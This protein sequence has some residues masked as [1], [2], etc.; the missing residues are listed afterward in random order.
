MSFVK[1][2]MM[3][4]ATWQE[5]TFKFDPDQM[6]LIKSLCGG[7]IMGLVGGFFPA[8]RAARVSPIEAMRA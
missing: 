5:V 1:V 6:I 2:S 3:N 4:F 8:V 7:L